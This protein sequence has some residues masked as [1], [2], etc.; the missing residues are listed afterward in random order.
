VCR[1]N[2]SSPRSDLKELPDLYER[3]EKA[4]NKLESAETKLLKLATKQIAK[5][6][7]KNQS[8]PELDAEANK[9]EISR[10]VPRKKRPTH[11]LGPLG[12]WGKKVDTI[13]WAREEITTTT[14]ELE[15]E[16]EILLGENGSAKYPP[17][18]AAFIQFHT[19]MAA[20][21]FAQYVACVSVIV[22]RSVGRPRLLPR[23][24][25]STTMRRSACLPATS[26]SRRTTS[27]GATSTSTRTSSA[28]VTPSRG[29]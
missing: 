16:R 6:N 17:E 24:G 25:A 11:K 18:S 9:G 7:K 13:E 22:K 2:S 19:Q 1:L 3:R 15:K 20:H 29:P 4:C 23:A 28:P 14:K 5:N 27:S 10:F 8:P 12:L 26:R 21:M